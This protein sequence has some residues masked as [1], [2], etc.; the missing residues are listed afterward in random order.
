MS[1]DEEV[2]ERSPEGRY[3]RYAQ[4]VGTGSF[5][6]VWKGQD[7]DTAREVAWNTINIA[8][9]KAAL[10]KRIMEEVMLLRRLSHPC[11]LQFY[12]SWLLPDS[13]Q[14]VFVTELFHAGTLK[15]FTRKYPISMAQVKKYCRSILECLVY[16][17]T[18]DPPVIHRDLK[19][20][21]IF[22]DGADGNIKIGDLGLSTQLL[23]NS[24]KA[25][26]VLGTPEF[27]APEMYEAEYTETVDIY[28]FGMC[29]L[30][31]I[32]KRA[33]YEE[34]ANNVAAVMKAVT[35][36]QLPR[37]LD[38]LKEKWP[39]AYEFVHRCIVAGEHDSRPSATSLLDDDFLR[40]RSED[41]TRPTAM[42]PLL[43][44]SKDGKGSDHPGAAHGAQGD[45]AGSVVSSVASGSNS[46][47]A[48]AA[49]PGSSSDVGNR[50]TADGPASGG[51]TGSVQPLRRGEGSLSTIV[52]ARQ[53]DGTVVL[54][55]VD[56]GESGTLDVSVVGEFA[57]PEIQRPAIALPDDA[58][59]RSS[60]PSDG[61]P[62][63]VPPVDAC[64][65]STAASHA[66]SSP[67]P[68][69][70]DSAAH[71]RASTDRPSTVD[72]Q[73]SAAGSRT[74]AVPGNEGLVDADSTAPAP[75]S[76]IPSVPSTVASAP[77]GL[78]QTG[79]T[80]PDTSAPVLQA[81]D[82][83]AN[84]QASATCARVSPVSQADA[85]VLAPGTSPME[86]VRL[87]A[88]TD[89]AAKCDPG[90]AAEPTT[91]PLPRS[92]GPQG[93]A[94]NN[95]AVLAPEGG[96]GLPPGQ[97]MPPATPSLED[98]HR[99]CARIPALEAAMQELLRR[100]AYLAA[101]QEA[102]T[103]AVQ[104]VSRAVASLASQQVRAPGGGSA[105]SP[106][107]VD[108]LNTE[109]AQPSPLLAKWPASSTT[110]PSSSPLSAHG[111]PSSREGAH[112]APHETRSAGHHHRSPGHLVTQL[113]VNT[114]T[115][116]GHGDSGNGT[117]AVAAP[118]YLN[119]LDGLAHAPPL[120]LREGAV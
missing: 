49:T 39:D 89:V 28:A 20:D 67:P 86:P 21:N 69:A 101:Q 11:L 93:L 3:V 94:C 43:E 104:G 27:M 51:E 60:T 102:L 108:G 90:S 78:P 30:E 80:V 120:S 24:E 114:G 65:A 42:V 106:R 14:V 91:S 109:G 74:D 57:P 107:P 48:G 99:F 63:V 72:V 52:A 62:G 71:M 41:K 103:A 113:D 34:C 81:P 77:A 66:S 12:G 22:I 97:A 19:C 18:Q 79:A 40:I 56:R 4:K 87:A 92:S 32:T 55:A 37:G 84:T 85:A 44:E 33:P 13:M 64:G 83:L 61:G 1:N 50:T 88:T 9:Y 111:A 58:G 16:L 45:A 7:M 117:T 15:E 5:K 46:A 73:N 110:V 54:A 96:A 98:L 38:E 68:N 70:S 100:Q 59:P 53:S 31:M 10:R 23:P 118:A 36:G 35:S 119:E 115:V 29:V 26:T 116:G 76:A 95:G 112:V 6:T 82:V 8:H 2:I 17:H 47:A 105:K 75:A 25:Y